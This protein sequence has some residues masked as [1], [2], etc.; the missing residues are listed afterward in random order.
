MLCPLPTTW[1]WALCTPFSAP[2]SPPPHPPPPP[3]LD[4]PDLQNSLWPRGQAHFFLQSS[5]V[6]LQILP[7]QQV[8]TPNGVVGNFSFSSFYTRLSLNQIIYNEHV[9]FV[10]VGKKKYIDCKIAGGETADKNKE[11]FFCSAK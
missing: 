5:A 11:S 2:A 1:A 3:G 8:L 10:L 4:S 7:E 6:S 9:L